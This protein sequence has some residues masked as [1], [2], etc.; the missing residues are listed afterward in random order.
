MGCGTLAGMKLTLLAALF[1]LGTS[2]GVLFKAGPHSVY[3]FT[4]PELGV[5]CYVVGGTGYAQVP[6][7]TCLKVK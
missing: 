1:A 7:L 6:S 2:D 4:D 3:R 5:A